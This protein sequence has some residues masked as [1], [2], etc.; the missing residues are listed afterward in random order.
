MTVEKEHRHDGGGKEV[1]M[2]D[3]IK[4]SHLD[5]QKLFG[6]SLQAARERA[7]VGIIPGVKI[8]QLKN[9]KGYFLWKSKLE[10]DIGRELTEEDF[11]R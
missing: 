7:K 9:R 1:L 6:C 2:T 5:T 10:K 3:L 8:V 4:L 11:V